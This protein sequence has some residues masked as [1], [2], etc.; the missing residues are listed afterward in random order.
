MIIVQLQQSPV[1]S[2]CAG[3]QTLRNSYHLCCL[4]IRGI[5]VSTQ[6]KN[7]KFKKTSKVNVLYLNLPYQGENSQS[8]LDIVLLMGGKDI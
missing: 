5:G 7:M 6:F 8:I 2:N 3:I 4:E 1:D